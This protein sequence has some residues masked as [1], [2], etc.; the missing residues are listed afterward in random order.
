MRRLVALF[1]ALSLLALPSA[2]AAQSAGDEQYADPFGQT[3]QP[4][5]SQGE[6]PTGTQGRRPR[7]RRRR[8]PRPRSRPWRHRSTAAP[9]LPPPGLPAHLL[10]GAGALLLAAAALLRRRV[11]LTP[12]PVAINARAAVRREIGGVERWAR[13]LVRAACRGCGPSA[14]R[15]SA[16]RRALAH[17]AGQA[18]EQL[19]LPLAARRVRAA[20][21]AGEPRAAGRAA[22][23]WW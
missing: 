5:G 14:T 7:P 4:S 18:W 13:E 11:A 21:L 10:A 1:L 12:A 22:A 15:C 9:T 3:E 20:A 2:A 19:A 16:R 23:T 17:R 6:E 8:P